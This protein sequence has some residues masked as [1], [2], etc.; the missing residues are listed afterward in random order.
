MNLSQIPQVTLSNSDVTS[1]WSNCWSH[2]LAE[3][4]LASSEDRPLPDLLSVVESELTPL[5]SSYW[6]YSLVP[7]SSVLSML[8]SERREICCGASAIIVSLLLNF[9]K[10][11]CGSCPLDH[12]TFQQCGNPECLCILFCTFWVMAVLTRPPSH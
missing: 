3:L 12:Y 7:C 6:E 11:A 9:S 10:M 8:P 5:L 1:C 2:D 4:L